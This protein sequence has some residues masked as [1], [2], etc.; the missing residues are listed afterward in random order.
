MSVKHTV[1][2]DMFGDPISEYSDREAVEDGSLV[3]LNERD[4]ITR[5]VWEY[6]ADHLPGPVNGANSSPPQRWP[7]D[8]MRWITA[9]DGYGRAQAACIGMLEQHAK[10]AVRTYAEENG[11]YKLAA[12]QGP[13]GVILA[14]W[15][16]VEAARERFE[17]NPETN[18]GGCTVTELWILPNARGVTLMFPSDY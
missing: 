16:G 11:I 8:L 17:I 5:A 6:L 10:R 7:V 9:K 2:Q 18:I 14:L 3:A 1:L 12:V 13:G 15:E 4:R